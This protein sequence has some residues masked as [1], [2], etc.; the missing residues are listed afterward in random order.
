[1]F[2]DEGVPIDM[3][4]ICDEVAQVDG[5]MWGLIFSLK[6][7]VAE[8]FGS[9]RHRRVVRGFVNQLCH[10]FL[11]TKGVGLADAAVC[12]HCVF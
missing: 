6:R 1:M 2:S 10:K 8:R 12:S 4:K 9:F 11:I 7:E 3:Q 5:N